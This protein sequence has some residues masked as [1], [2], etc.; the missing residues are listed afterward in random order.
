MV[1]ATFVVFACAIVVACVLTERS[2]LSAVLTMLC[3][4]TWSY[5]VH[6]LTHEL[7][8]E[9]RVPFLRLHSLMHHNTVDVEFINKIAV[10]AWAAELF[11]NSVGAGAMFLLFVP[12]V[13]RFLDWRVVLFFSLFY[14]LSHHF[15]YHVCHSDFHKAHHEDTSVNYDFLEVDCV[16]GSRYPVEE[17]RPVMLTAMY[18]L[19]I[20][21]AAV[22]VLKYDPEAAMRRIRCYLE[23]LHVHDA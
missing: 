8:R 18:L 5:W 22:A 23:T 2:V 16:F 15:V 20:V 12:H 19:S 4:H 21:V 1:A 9:N 3:L 10:E 6:R 13:H 17:R 11:M 7:D 14:T